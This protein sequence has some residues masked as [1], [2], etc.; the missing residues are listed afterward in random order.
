MTD[1]GWVDDFNLHYEMEN[2]SFE[3]GQHFI[4]SMTMITWCLKHYHQ[5]I[6]W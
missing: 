2:R 4:I 1:K 6:L 5:G 3:R